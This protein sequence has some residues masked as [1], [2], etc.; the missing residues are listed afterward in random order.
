M[1]D[2][3]ATN[4]SAEELRAIL[5]PNWGICRPTE[6]NRERYAKCITRK[7]YEAAKKLAISRRTVEVKK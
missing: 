4:A 3:Y 5:G 6:R 2:Y 7:E 1:S